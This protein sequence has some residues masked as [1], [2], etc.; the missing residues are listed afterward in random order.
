MSRHENLTIVLT[1]IVGYTRMT[2]ESSRAAMRQLL[3]QHDATVLPLVRAYGGRHVKSIG[4]ALLLSFRSATDAV[5]CAMAIQDAIA[6]LRERDAACTE[7]HLRIGI[8]LGEVRVE[9]RDV[10]GEA[11][12]IAAR[13][14]A[15]TP[16][17]EIYLSDTVYLAMSKGDVDAREI[18]QQTLRGVHRPVQVYAAV[19]PV[20]M[21]GEPDPRRPFGGLH[22]EQVRARPMVA[23]TRSALTLAATTA[24]GVWVQQSARLS[25]GAARGL[26]AAVGA[27]V[28]SIALTVAITSLVERQLSAPI[29][30]A[31]ATSVVEPPDAAIAPPQAQG[32]PAAAA[33][34]LQLARLDLPA[35]TPV[36]V[37]PEQRVA[38]WYRGS[39]RALEAQDYPAL[40]QRL[41][42][43]QG[44]GELDGA[45]DLIAGHLAYAQGRASTALDAYEAAVPMVGDLAL[46]PRLGRN[47]VGML[48]KHTARA[49]SLLRQVASPAMVEAL[50]QRSGEAGFYGRHHAVRIL[51]D[52]GLQARVRWYDYAIEELNGRSECEDRRAAVHLLHELGDPR[53]IPHLEQARGEGFGGWMRNRCLRRSADRAI[54][55]LKAAG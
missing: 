46:D 9:R 50:S 41:Q 18:G 51:S 28:A 55:A 2:S 5:L 39:L 37:S 34:P 20:G 48:A 24:R 25:R 13:L 6:E 22:R 52:L 26:G 32:E 47:L 12:N 40:E 16:A 38:D 43:A 44:D 21:A 42:Q 30:G 4:D 11:V 45:A 29:P 54:A 8:A 31:T 14:E 33:D 17:D 10:F 7:L 19:A 15:L 49:E 1:D 27:G 36:P 3:A 23:R 35:P 53:A